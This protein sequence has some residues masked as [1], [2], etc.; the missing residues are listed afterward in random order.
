MNERLPYGARTVTEMR[1][2]QARLGRRWQERRRGLD[3]QLGD[4]RPATPL[5]PIISTVLMVGAVVGL[6]FLLGGCGDYACAPARFSGYSCPGPM[7]ER[8]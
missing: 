1:I 5:L 6:L 8:R 4:I 2:N 3:E 7:V